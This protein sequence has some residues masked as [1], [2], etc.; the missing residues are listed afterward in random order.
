V[1]VGR[2]SIER[3]G[4]GETLML[5]YRSSLKTRD[6]SDQSGM[7]QRAGMGQKWDLIWIEFLA[8]PSTTDTPGTAVR[9]VSLETRKCL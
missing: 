5:T 9:R 4:K 2:L 7:T 8:H 3:G 1:N 6:I